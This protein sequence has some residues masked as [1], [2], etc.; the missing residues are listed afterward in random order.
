MFC[1]AARHDSDVGREYESTGH[2]LRKNGS[3]D[4][5]RFLMFVWRRIRHLAS[6]RGSRT[7][8]LRFRARNPDCMIVIA[9][10]KSSLTRS[11]R[12]ATVHAMIDDG[13]AYLCLHASSF[14]MSESDLTPAE[15]SS[16]V[17]FA[18]QQRP[19]RADAFRNMKTEPN[20]ARERFAAK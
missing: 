17:V 18:P 15:K 10:S 14:V 5:C 12:D 8:D 6:R 1:V 13:M 11:G 20:K 16:C 19:D 2:R 3:A 7:K 4:L 9:N